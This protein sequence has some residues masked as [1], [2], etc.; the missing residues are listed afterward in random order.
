M[1]RKN[2]I[3]PNFLFETV[4]ESEITAYLKRS[5]HGYVCLFF[6]G[7]RNDF[8]LIQPSS[9]MRNVRCL[10]IYKSW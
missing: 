6:H 7:S 5:Y 1:Y 3:Y 8:V 4:I 9:Y 10:F 2:I